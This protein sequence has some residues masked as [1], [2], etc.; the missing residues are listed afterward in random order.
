MPQTSNKFKVFISGEINGEVLFMTIDQE[1]M[2]DIGIG[3]Q[4]G[5]PC[6]KLHKESFIA[7]TRVL[8]VWCRRP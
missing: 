4:R 3:P 1:A 6:K 2:D 8:I 7:D 5:V